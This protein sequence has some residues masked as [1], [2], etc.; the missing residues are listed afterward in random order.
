MNPNTL[1]IAGAAIVFV[2]L[3]LIFVGFC[4]LIKR[5]RRP[6]TPPLTPDEQYE[7][8]RLDTIKSQVADAEKRL[9]AIDQ[10]RVSVEQV[11][12]ARQSVLQRLD[13]QV[14]ET[15]K[16]LE[17]LKAEIAAISKPCVSCGGQ[18][19][20]IACSVCG[21]KRK[22]EKI[23]Y[24]KVPWNEVL[25]YFMTIAEW[26]DPSELNFGNG[27]ILLPWATQDETKFSV[28]GVNYT[29]GKME[30]EE[31]GGN[32]WWSYLEY[33]HPILGGITIIN[34]INSEGDH[35]IRDGYND[36]IE[37]SGGDYSDMR[38]DYAKAIKQG[39]T[40]LYL[41]MKNEEVA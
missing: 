8:S 28:G 19:V 10:Q 37:L 40:A 3:L 24:T 20:G 16:R 1:L 7:M 33:E 11:I 5:L 34:K 9:R 23:P 30:D 36:D 35:L 26:G 2:S 12:S 13:P 15:S 41:W 31:N 21:V 32:D 27:E 6:K 25:E 29:W 39:L 18:M 17:N 22:S 14:D 38:A 4:K